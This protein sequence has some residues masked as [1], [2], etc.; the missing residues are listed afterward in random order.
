MKPERWQ[1]IERVFHAALER[2]PHQRPAFLDEACAGDQAL[3]REIDSLLAQHP[4]AESFLEGR[5]LEVA[6]R[7]L[8]EEQATREGQQQKEMIGRTITHYRVLEKLGG[9]GMGVV[10]RAEDTSLD[11]CVALKFL[12]E[13]L[14][15]DRRFL[16]RFQREA[17]AASALNH[18]NICTIHEIAEHAGRPFIVM[19]CLEGQ[20]LK[21]L[22]SVAP[23]SP[24]A[25]GGQRPP[26]PLDLLLD[27]A[28]QVADAL[29]AAHTKGII[30]RDIK[31]ANI[32][33]TERGQSKILD[34][35]L[36]KVTGLGTRGSGLGKGAGMTAAAA[37]TPEESLTSTGMAMGTFD[38]MS[39]EQV[40]AEEL[41]ARTDLFSFGLV[42]YEMA[43]GRR[44]F[45]GD[46]PA[47]IFEA[48]LNRAPIPPLRLNPELPDALDK[49]IDKSL[50][51]DRELRY[52]TAADLRA[53]LQRLKRETELARSAGVSPAVGAIREPPLQKRWLMVLGGLALIA[54]A[55]VLV[56][57]NVAGLRDR[58][59]GRAAATPK[60]E[61]IAVLPLENLSGDKDQ[62]YFADGMTEELITSLGKVSALR[63]ISRTSVMQ[64]KGTK[65]PL[66]EIA[67]EL[68]VDALV[69]GTVDRSGNRV[70]ITANLV[71]GAT[72][73][74]LWA[75]S[76]ERDLRDIL[77]LQ[78]EV[79]R[80]IANGIQIT[81]TPQEHARLVSA[82]PVNPEAYEAYLKGRH[83]QFLNDAKAV[84]F[85]QR[86]T[87]IDP[88]WAPAY[89]AIVSPTLFEGLPP[90]EACAKA[91]GAAGRALELDDTLSEAHSAM[92]WVRFHCDWDW[93]GT[94]REY[95][96]AMEL[97]PTNSQAR[98]HY[99]HYLIAMRRFDESLI[100]SKRALERDPL[101]EFLNFHLAW[102]YVWAHQPDLAI[103]QSRKVL[104][105][106]PNSPQGHVFRMW[107]YEMK[108]LYEQAI[109]DELDSKL[110]ARLKR[111]YGRFGARGYWQC[112]LDSELEQ[113]KQ[114]YVSPLGIAG[115]YAQLGQRDEAFAWLEKAYDERSLIMA[116]YVSCGHWFDPL[117]SDPRFQDLLR[118][119]NF[120]P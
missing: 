14:A 1:E 94:E 43:T 88:T 45:S 118:R 85:L 60:I 3:R 83:L 102:H 116:E 114:G 26:L 44:A 4:E 46:S 81:V 101:S 11:R 65:K 87:Q 68:N 6:A 10:Y 93:P 23:V 58:L 51:K 5:A 104:E 55:V 82:R 59:L 31:P 20:T 35:G 90:M 50:Q 109:A 100:E 74:H 32:F 62:E 15:Q 92:G 53:D 18:P 75:E 64:Y 17:R 36:A 48:I 37:A 40:R 34:F 76:Y 91:R 57:L 56:A 99:S 111:A 27:L 33:V 110:A 107:A 84:E 39:P 77:A 29:E 19:E 78:S 25:A 73:S 89:A 113:S 79:A 21:H 117:R 13:E 22:I 120:P 52:Q 72:E 105:V 24:Q 70:R 61:S 115:L 71:R 42:L 7:A 119:M 112:R 54:V 69:E 106:W 97:D 38:Y 67:R 96:R 63:V 98:H 30:H 41:D 86:A 9:G 28:V 108:G 8:A 80:A 66:P 2:E 95:K 16:E 49:I 47:T 103:E 12:P